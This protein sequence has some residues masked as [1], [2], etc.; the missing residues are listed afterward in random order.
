MACILNDLEKH[1]GVRF[2]IRG[3]QIGARGVYREIGRKISL[4][5]DLIGQREGAIRTYRKHRD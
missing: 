3:E 4:R 2:L 1:N 5:V